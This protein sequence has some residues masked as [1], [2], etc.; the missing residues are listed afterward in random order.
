MNVYMLRLVKNF[1]NFF[2]LWL[3]QKA[4]SHSSFYIIVTTNTPA[5][6]K[7]GCNSMTNGPVAVF[8]R[9]YSRFVR[10]SK[11]VGSYVYCQTDLIVAYV[12][13]NILINAG[14][15]TNLLISQHNAEYCRHCRRLIIICI[16]LAK[17]SCTKCQG[18]SCCT[19]YPGPLLM[20]LFFLV[21]T[22]T[23]VLHYYEQWSYRTILMNND[24]HCI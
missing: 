2:Y 5:I 1:H 16:L 15:Q 3:I 6:S 12:T 8:G 7:M 23:A 11:S 20:C 13:G 22:E 10:P 14:S 18:I 21:I 24:I 19:L 9:L 17:K 4:I